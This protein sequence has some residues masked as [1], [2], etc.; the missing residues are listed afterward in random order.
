[1]T[2]E[3]TPETLPD[4]VSVANLD[5]TRSSLRSL[6]PDRILVRLRLVGSRD[7]PVRS[8]LGGHRSSSKT[9]TLLFSGRCR[10]PPFVYSSIPS[11]LPRESGCC[12]PQTP[13]SFHHGYLDRLNGDPRSRL[14]Y[15]LGNRGAEVLVERGQPIDMRDWRKRNQG[16]H[17]RYVAHQAMITNVRIALMLALKERPDVRLLFFKPEGLALRDHVVA[18]AN[19]KQQTLP[20]NPDGFF[21]LSFP[22]CQ[23]TQPKLLF[24]WRPIARR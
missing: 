19:G 20:I 21:G 9:E 22:S 23:R 14:S 18:T 5:A 1:M 6:P 13:A 12:L 7:S 17:D 15:A 4:T 8:S 24:S 10:L 2:P 11:P 16:L 3:T